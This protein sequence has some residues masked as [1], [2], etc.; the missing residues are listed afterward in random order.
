MSSYFSLSTEKPR[1]RKRRPEKWI[2]NIAKRNKAIGLGY[3][4]TAGVSRPGRHMKK[5]CDSS[6]RLKCWEKITNEQRQQLFD[7]YYEIGDLNRQRE[8]IAQLIDRT[9]TKERIRRRSPKPGQVIKPRKERKAN[10]YYCLRVLL[11]NER[12]RVCGQMFRSTFDISR[13]NV[14]TCLRKTNDEGILV[15]KDLRG[16]NRK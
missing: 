11:N 8:Y 1:W 15:E 12:I 10:I 4:S 13:A 9:R 6:C 7:E 16:G 3:L 2:R 5:P 14:E